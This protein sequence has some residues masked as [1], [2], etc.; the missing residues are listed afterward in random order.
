MAVVVFNARPAR[1]VAGRVYPDCRESRAGWAWRIRVV[2]A[3]ADEV[4]AF[5]QQARVMDMAVEASLT[6]M[7]DTPRAPWH[8]WS[9]EG[10][11]KKL[12]GSVA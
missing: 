10:K 5:Q 6:A 9:K 7:A 2:S 1:P 12:A 4:R 8:S 11:G 3:A